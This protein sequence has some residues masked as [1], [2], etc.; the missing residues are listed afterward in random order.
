[1]PSGIAV[2]SVEE[3]LLSKKKGRLK[4]S[5]FLIS[6]NGFELKEEDVDRFLN[7]DYFP[8]VKVGKKGEYEINARPLVKSIK[9]ALP[10]KISLDV[11][12]TSAFSL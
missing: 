5:H 8:V 10:N 7:S 6:L 11:K 1:M 2:T 3:I 9:L 4:E 12:H